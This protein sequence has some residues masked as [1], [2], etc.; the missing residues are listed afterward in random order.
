MYKIIALITSLIM[1][2]T[3]F[4]CAG[5][6][7]DESTAS[8][9]SPAEG[10]FDENG[11]TN[12]ETAEVT[13]A[14]ETSETAQ[15]DDTTASTAA[16]GKTTKTASEKNSETTAKADVKKTTAKKTG[17]PETKAEI[18][19]AYAAAY[20]KTKAAGT[21]LGKSEMKIEDIKIDGKENAAL[22]KMLGGMSGSADDKD[23][24]LPP[25][26]ETNKYMTC[27]ITADDIEKATYKDNGNG[28]A[29]ITLVPKRVVNPKLG[30]DSQGKML[31]VVDDFVKLME[32]FEDS[33]LSWAQG[34]A[35]SNVEADTYG[36]YATVTYNLKTNMITSA[37]YVLITHL[38]ISHANVLMFKDKSVSATTIYTMTFPQ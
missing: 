1:V 5:S 15:T 11:E 32:G 25:D 13:E 34:D 28:T 20:N 21:L 6:K 38:S 37:T 12:S 36:G 33:G 2:L 26:S 18:V 35:N 27:L 22:S 24:P 10:L 31:N 7:D 4:G 8:T 14:S 23:M 29:T 3:L 9:T 16:D 17:K 19:A 30:K